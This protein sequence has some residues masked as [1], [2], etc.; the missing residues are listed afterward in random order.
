MTKPHGAWTDLFSDYLAEELETEVRSSLEAHVAECGA[1]RTVLEEI[2]DV[3]SQARG[4]PERRP[5][6]DLWP[7]IA[8]AIDMPV[9][10][11]APDSAQV[12]A[13]PTARE[14]VDPRRIAFTA[15]QLAAAAVVL[16]SLS[17]ATTIW[18]GPGLGVRA[19]GDVP[20]S[21]GAPSAVTAASTV[22]SPP[23]A[24]SEELATL[25][26]VLELAHERLDPNTVRV[27]ERNLAV[28]EKAIAD[29]QQALVLDPENAFLAE[30][31][32]RVYE[33]KIEYLRD[34]ARVLDWAG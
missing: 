34:A 20:A 16:I 10:A 22:A 21:V 9:R 32:E 28:I 17:A 5:A 2:R 14:T 19:G 11:Q 25:E 4:L 23:A 3:V 12:I 31:L 26:D 7:G 33:R 27:I 30:H 1:C 29:S 15:P 24:L 18:A 8:A 6:R 13:L